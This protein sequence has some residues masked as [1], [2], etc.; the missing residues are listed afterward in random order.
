MRQIRP[1]QSADADGIRAVHL[2]AFAARP[3]EANLVDRLRQAGQ[4]AVSLVALSG[5][6]ITGHILF[7]PVSLVPAQHGQRGLGLA[8]LA[9]RPNDQRRGIGAQLVTRGLEACHAAGVDF[10]VVLGDP[11]YYGRFGFRRAGVF[12][13]ENEYGAE[14]DFMAIELSPAGLSGMAGLVQYRPEFRDTGC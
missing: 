6:E 11:R 12:Q 5:G 4:A 8:P 14:D 3:N 2:A 7:S 10:V 9:V 1:E 13:L